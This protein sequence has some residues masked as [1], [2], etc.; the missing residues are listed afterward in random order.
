[1]LEPKISYYKIFFDKNINYCDELQSILNTN[2]DILH[3]KYSI[4]YYKNYMTVTIKG[5]DNDTDILDINSLLDKWSETT[6]YTCTINV[7][8]GSHIYAVFSIE[9]G[10][11]TK[12]IL[13]DD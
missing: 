13:Y 11:I 2:K 12:I 1:M 5:T 10:L 7:F 6:Y 9:D 8:T 4:S 3:A